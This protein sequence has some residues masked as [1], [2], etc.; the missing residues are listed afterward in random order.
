MKFEI[1]LDWTWVLHK[2]RLVFLVGVFYALYTYVAPI[3]GF[4]WILYFILNDLMEIVTDIE[5]MKEERQELWRNISHKRKG[6]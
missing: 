1:K 3:W 5:T 2:I 6:F 4:V